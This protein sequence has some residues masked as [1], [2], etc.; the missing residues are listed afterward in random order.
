LRISSEGPDDATV[1]MVA[2]TELGSGEARDTTQ[3]KTFQDN[4]TYLTRVLNNI[5][6][7]FL[8]TS[9]DLYRLSN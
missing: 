6:L 1:S 9:M 8:F 4:P 2:L 5:G 3:N 7:F